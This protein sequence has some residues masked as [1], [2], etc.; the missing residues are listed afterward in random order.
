[1]GTFAAPQ[2]FP[3]RDR[4]ISGISIGVLVVETARNTA[5]RGLRHAVL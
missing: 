4:I 3:I 1:M 2:N 5:A